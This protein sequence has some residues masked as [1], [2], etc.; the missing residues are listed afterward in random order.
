MRDYLDRFVLG[1]TIV[2]RPLKVMAQLF[3]PI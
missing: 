2:T 3:G 1:Y